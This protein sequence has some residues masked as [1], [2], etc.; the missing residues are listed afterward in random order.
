MY[1][2]IYFI[3]LPDTGLKIGIMTKAKLNQAHREGNLS[4]HQLK[5]YF[6]AI[7]T[8]YLTCAVYAK[9]WFPLQDQLLKSARF[10]DLNSKEEITMDQLIFFYNR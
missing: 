10:L 8:F 5:A 6:Q 2:S 3:I 1:Y 7:K 4:D 9:K